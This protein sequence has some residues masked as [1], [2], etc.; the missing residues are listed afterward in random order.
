M[1]TQNLNNQLKAFV[2]ER[3][4][5]LRWELP[6][7]PPRISIAIPSYN[8]AAYLERTLL[9]ILNQN[10]ANTEILF[11]D[12]GSKDGSLEI[13]EKY[14][15]EIA[16]VVSE[17]D[18][19]QSDAI[20]KGLRKS[21]GDLMGFQNADDL[22][23][24]GAF[25][26]IAWLRHRKPKASM[27]CGNAIII[28]S[29]DRIVRFSKFIRPTFKR[30]FLQGFVFT[31]QATFWTRDAY[32]KH[33]EFSETL[34]YGMDY[35]YFLRILSDSQAA[36]TD[37]YLGAFRRV[38]GTKTVAHP[39]RGYEE[40]A[41]IRKQYDCDPASFCSRLQ[42]SA[43]SFYRLGRHCLLHPPVLFGGTPITEFGRRHARQNR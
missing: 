23:L 38:E 41:L 24:P 22:Y 5:A 40:V 7:N 13:L 2:T 26:A 14:K 42:K 32:Q 1:D 18:N 43:G 4:P 33:G 8:S 37:D 3:N 15:D 12:A 9:S 30:A 29:D 19:G 16:C 21:T 17:P 31:S 25:A 10:Y 27:Y 20:N 35:D 11:M 34:H 39:E 6:P 28:D 36:A